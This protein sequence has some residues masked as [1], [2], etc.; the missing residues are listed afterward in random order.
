METLK[1]QYM[2]FVGDEP[3]YLEYFGYA[4]SLAKT[5]Q[6]DYS[7]I[8]KTNEEKEL[9]EKYKET[10]KIPQVTK[11]SIN[12]HS[13]APTSKKLNIN[14]VNASTSIKKF[15][16]SRPKYNQQLPQREKTLRQGRPTD[17]RLRPKVIETFTSTSENPTNE[18]TKNTT[19]Q[20]NYRQFIEDLVHTDNQN[21][22]DSRE[23]EY[24]E[25][26]AEATDSEDDEDYDEPT[27]SLDN[28]SSYFLLI[29]Q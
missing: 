25:D 26:A 5:L 13:E 20:K 23:T 22:F 15:S 28:V 19:S 7:Y 10:K 18:T 16:E 3:L 12:D 21:E 1:D 11:R 27:T 8:I 9:A 29:K 17:P 2:E 14:S 24:E 6:K 4:C